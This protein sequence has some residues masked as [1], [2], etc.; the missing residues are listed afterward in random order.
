[1]SLLWREGDL[2]GVSI[3]D[4]FS[5][6]VTQVCRVVLHHVWRRFQIPPG[7]IKTRRRKSRHRVSSEEKKKKKKGSIQEG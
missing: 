6:P 3:V 5:G 4:K 2:W 7:E 1:M